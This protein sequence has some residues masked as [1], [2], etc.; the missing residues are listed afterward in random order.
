MRSQAHPDAPTIPSVCT[1][2]T[3]AASLGLTERSIRRYIADGR[4]PAYRI[5]DKQIRL[6]VADVEALMVP[7][8]AQDAS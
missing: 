6:R 4:L 5:G 1:V 3:A 2:Q 7:I 8:A